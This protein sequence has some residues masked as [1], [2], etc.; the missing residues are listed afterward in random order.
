MDGIKHEKH[1][2]WRCVR[3]WRLC[4][5]LFRALLKLRTQRLGRCKE[6]MNHL[7]L[8]PFLWPIAAKTQEWSQSDT[9]AKLL[10]FSD[11]GAVAY[12]TIIFHGEPESWI[13]DSLQTIEWLE[14]YSI[15]KNKYENC[16]LDTTWKLYETLKTKMERVIYYCPGTNYCASLFRIYASYITSSYVPYKQVH[17]SSRFSHT[18]THSVPGHSVD[19]E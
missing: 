12:P 16:K 5:C 17:T 15:L 13:L 11:P 18:K 7:L 14:E 3:N 1:P 10:A 19:S 4:R 8:K 6:N 9:L 2:N